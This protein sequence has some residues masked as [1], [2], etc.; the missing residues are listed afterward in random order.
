MIVCID[1]VEIMDGLI[2]AFEIA[3]VCKESL[4]PFKLIILGKACQ[5]LSPLQN[6]LAAPVAIAGSKSFVLLDAAVPKVL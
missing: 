3:K 2:P 6:L 4:N 1:A 5:V